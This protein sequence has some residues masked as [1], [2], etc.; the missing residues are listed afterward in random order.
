ML[1]KGLG[2]GGAERLLVE[3]V[4]HHDPSLSLSVAYLVPQKRALVTELEHLGIKP[5]CIGSRSVFDPRWMLRLR[6]IIVGYGVDVAHVHSP[7]VAVGTRLVLATIPRERRPRLVTTEHNVWASHARPTRIADRLTASCDSAHLAV[8]SAVRSS[9]PA[10]LRTRTE[11]VRYGVDLDRV[12][13]AQAAREGVRA[14][15]GVTGDELV[16]G[17]VA[18]LRST[19]G[20]PDLLAAACL[21]VERF[22]RA[23]FVA[24]GQG[25]LEDE[26]RRLHAGSGLGDRF[27]LLG[28]RADAIEVMSGFDVFC[29]AS[30]HEGLPIALMEALALGIP[31][32]ATAVGGVP[33]L[34]TDGHDAILVPAGQ[35]EKLAEALIELLQNPE[36]R[37]LLARHAREHGRGLSVEHAIRRVEA[38]YRTLCAT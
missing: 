10:R 13:S 34:V 22:D 4:R 16:I 3:S 12:Y 25:P 14:A 32:V 7:V 38:L 5:Q 33:E 15:L 29:L 36:R 35:P 1:I 23:R 11:I 19:K 26:I 24:I 31:I 30:H 9:M 2:P 28:Y 27:T 20:Y 17:T 18:N 37:S 21:V 8:S 6:R